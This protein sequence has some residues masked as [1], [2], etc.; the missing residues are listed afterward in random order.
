MMV[1]IHN[2]LLKGRRSKKLL[3]AIKRNI[4]NEIINTKIEKYP[5]GQT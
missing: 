5:D 4:F 3:G 1:I 2:P